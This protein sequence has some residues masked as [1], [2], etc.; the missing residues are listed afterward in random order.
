MGCPEL[1]ESRSRPGWRS[2]APLLRCG[3]W[4]RCGKTFL[5]P[6]VAS[7]RS[8]LSSGRRHLQ[9]ST[10]ESPQFYSITRWLK[11][12]TRGGCRIKHRQKRATGVPGAH[13]LAAESLLEIAGEAGPAMPAARADLRNLELS[14]GGRRC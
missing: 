9:G 14:I 5:P 11:Y 10:L 2:L 8:G 7:V 6:R 1:C 12:R 3:N 4:G 13:P